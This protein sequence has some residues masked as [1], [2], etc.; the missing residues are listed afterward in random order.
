M[1][2]E[3]A[4]ITLTGGQARSLRSLLE[5]AHDGSMVTLT[6]QGD[7]SVVAALSEATFAIETDG[8]W[9]VIG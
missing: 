5:E 9:A 6:Q 2:V 1:A 3:L 7:L 8:T 4:Q